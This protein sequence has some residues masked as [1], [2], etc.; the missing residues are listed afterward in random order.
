MQELSEKVDLS[1][2]VLG[3]DINSPIFQS[4]LNKLNYQI[5]EVIKKVY[6][7]EFES[8]DISLKITLKVPTCIEEF[9]AVNEFNEPVTKEYKY[10]SLYFKNDITTTLKKVDKTSGEYKSIKE[11]KEDN[12]EFIEVPIEN[13]QVSLFDR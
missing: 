9:P 12:G 10:R 13:P 8:G 1:K 7:K 5:V 2:K 11:L 4:M 6:D 3:V